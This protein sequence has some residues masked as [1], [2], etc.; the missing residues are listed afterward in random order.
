LITIVWL[1]VAIG[2]APLALGVWLS[3]PRPAGAR[4]SA[5]V[6]AILYCAL[7]F[8]LTFFWQEL[9]LVIPKALTPGLHP[10]LFHNNHTWTGD[11]RWV[12]LLQ[13]TGAVATLVSGLAFAAALRLVRLRSPT[14]RSFAFWMAFQGL[15]QS[16]SQVALGT[17]LPG[18][19]MGRALAFLGLNEAA[20]LTLLALAV[21]AMALA[22]GWLARAYPANRGTSDAPG[23]RAFAYSMFAT[24]MLSILV[25]VPFREPR[26]LV[27]VA[28]VPLVVHLTGT[29]WVVLGSA[30]IRA[31]RPASEGPEPSLLVAVL[32]LAATLALFQL[33]LRPGIAF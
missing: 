6:G 30:R 9:W 11:S 12:D 21:L 17:L 16:L 4:F 14:W 24:T 2:A 13:G 8:N 18:N 20:K 23:G 3:R 22:G 1:T 27:E 10:V 29:G 25:L 15:Y 31:T 32:G 7:A 19:D 28:V 33:I 5:P 26:D